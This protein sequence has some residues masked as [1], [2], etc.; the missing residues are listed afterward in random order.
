MNRLFA[1]AIFG[2]VIFLTPTASFAVSC[3][4]QSL[5]CKTWA[6]GQGAQ[7]A[8]Y[9]AKCTREISACINRCKKGQKYFLGVFTGPGGGQHYPIDECN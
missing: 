6:S 1:F 7:A 2:S 8:S 3:S 4:Q 9:A 5:S